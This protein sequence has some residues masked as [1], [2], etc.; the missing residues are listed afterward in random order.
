MKTETMQ[1]K[2]LIPSENHFLFNEKEKIISEK[3]FIGKEANADDWQEITEEERQEILAK[4][5]EN[6]E[7]ID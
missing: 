7:R 5:R 6:I 3:V 2:I 1:I 4:E